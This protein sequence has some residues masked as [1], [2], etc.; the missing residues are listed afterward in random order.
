MAHGEALGLDVLLELARELEES[1]VVGD[2]RTVDAHT[3]ADGF[4]RRARI[5]KRPVGVGELDRVEVVPL[6]VL[7]DRELETVPGLDVGDHGGDGLESRGATGAPAALAHDQ[8]VAAI[9]G[10]TH[11]DR[12]QD[13]MSGDRLRELRQVIA[14]EHPAG[15]IGVRDDGV[16][17]DLRGSG[18][19]R[20]G[21]RRFGL[22]TRGGDQRPE[23][24][25]QRA[26]ACRHDPSP[27]L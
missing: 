12:L 15:L 16:D 13:A 22:S 6:D 20:R 21:R 1:K 17:R 4:L 2:A 24:A 8:L 11:D 10:P 3:L 23:A 26:T 14:V 5:G 9:R 19:A 18:R 25:S 7:H 27:L